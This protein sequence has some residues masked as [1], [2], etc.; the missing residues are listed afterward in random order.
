MTADGPVGSPPMLRAPR[1][2]G[3]SFPPEIGGVYEHPEYGPILV[4]RGSYMGDY[5][6]VSNHWTARR[7]LDDGSL[8]LEE[9]GFYAGRIKKL[10][11]T[12]TTIVKITR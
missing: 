12:M 5:D 2:D 4:H 10:K 8:G 11:H 7:I 3:L 6:R 1:D 9:L